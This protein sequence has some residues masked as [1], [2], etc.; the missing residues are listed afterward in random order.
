VISPARARWL[1][2]LCVLL[3]FLSPAVQAQAADQTLESPSVS[4]LLDTYRYQMKG[5]VRFLFFWFAKDN[6]GGGHISFLRVPPAAEGTRLEGTEVLFGSRPDRV[7]GKINRWGYGQELAY[8]RDPGVGLPSCVEESIFE[9]FMRHSG[10]GSLAEVR[11]SDRNEKAQNLF[12]Y[13]GIQSRVTPERAAT[14]IVHFSRQQDFDYNDFQP[15]VDAYR[16]R[17]AEGPADRTQTLA[18]TGGLYDAPLGFLSAVRHLIQAVAQR[19]ESGDAQWRSRSYALSYAY[20]AKAYRLRLAGIKHHA[21]LQENFWAPPPTGMDDSALQN[22]AEADFEL[23]A[24]SGGTTRK[25]SVW[26]PLQGAHRGVPLRIVDQP[27][28]WLRV[29]LNLREHVQEQSPLNRTSFAGIAAVPRGP[30][31]SCISPTVQTRNP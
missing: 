29:E 11:T 16:G 19:F 3:I 9:G 20:N 17:R 25:F 8:W 13:D 12:W 24:V 21:R 10:E 7:P 18:R 1:F 6:V 27:R 26:F 30:S 23:S 28:W 2:W 22:V 31:G 14:E 4:A 15:V 5:K